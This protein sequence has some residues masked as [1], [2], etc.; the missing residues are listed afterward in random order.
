[1]VDEKLG[2]SLEVAELGVSRL[3]RRDMSVEGWRLELL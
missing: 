1:M 2:E 3:R